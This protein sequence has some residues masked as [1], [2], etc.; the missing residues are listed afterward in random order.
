MILRY[1][2]ML[3]IC[4]GF[5]LQARASFNLDRTLAFGQILSES[6]VPGLP[7]VGLPV[8]KE[9]STSTASVEGEL[10]FS[11]NQEIIRAGF[12]IGNP[13]ENQLQPDTPGTLFIPFEVD[14]ISTAMLVTGLNEGTRYGLRMLAENASGTVT[15]DM[16]VFSTKLGF[17]GTMYKSHFNEPTGFI[18]GPEW[19][20]SD[21]NPVASFGIGTT[22]GLRHSEDV[23][24]YQLTSSLNKFSA[25]LTLVN[26]TGTHLEQIIIGYTGLVERTTT[27]RSPEWEVFVNGKNIKQLSYTTSKGIDRPGIQTIVDD[28]NIGD[29]DELRIKWSTE[30]VQGSGI[31][32]QIGLTD[33]HVGLPAVVN[34]QVTGDAGWRMYSAP[35]WY[36]SVSLINDISPIQ[37][38]PGQGVPVNVYTGYDGENWA[39]IV[40]NDSLPSQPWLRPGSGFL[41]YVF[42]NALAGSTPVGTGRTIPVVG[43]PHQ[44]DV[45]IP[46]HANG[47]RWNLLGNPY[48]E[49][50]DIRALQFDAGGTAVVQVWKDAPDNPDA[51]SPASG[52]WVLSN[53]S[54]FNNLIPAGQGFMWQNNPDNP[55]TEITFPLAGK[56]GFTSTRLKPYP[57]PRIEFLLAAEH[58]DGSKAIDRSLQLIAV[59]DENDVGKHTIGK[60]ASLTAEPQVMFVIENMGAHKNYLAQ[61]AIPA[62][63]KGVIEVPLCFEG[64]DNNWE[65]VTLSWPYWLDIP[66]QWS[67]E[68]RNVEQ[69]I[70]M[71]LRKV[72]GVNLSDY[73]SLVESWYLVV[74]NIHTTNERSDTS[75]PYRFSLSE[76]FPNPFNPSTS[77]ELMLPDYRH[78]R[79]EVFD[80]LG[81][82]VQVL[83]NE[84]RPAG[85]HI[86]SWDAQ[87]F[88]SGTYIVRVRAG[89]MTA[90]RKVTLIK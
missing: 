64:V 38:F 67:I 78:I 42:N 89:D 76:A 20:L 44:E 60:L 7:I 8:V 81:R 3:L 35:F 74:R 55:S 80:L 27:D 71:D 56:A 54:V 77:F 86:I 11:G 31:H 63:F 48:Q 87:Q 59:P 22:G 72:N 21:D 1:I 4:S 83:T 28:L 88:N 32:R 65:N 57:T 17:D 45:S 90:V 73:P 34:L 26:T 61:K 24:G 43:I 51:Q 53:S 70:T 50:F 68:L 5:T 10:L 13:D 84:Y 40:L 23:I 82:S 47:N 75:T 36:P 33:V 46:V 39:P 49:A 69:D 15:S 37:G 9:V 58:I 18:S 2:T 62:N 6:D 19:V 29:G 30:V 79:M 66:S 41:V 25:E 14:A 85:S 52:S 12:V 16:V